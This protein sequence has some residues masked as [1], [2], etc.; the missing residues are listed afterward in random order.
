MG[1]VEGDD[2]AVRW[3]EI[4][5]FFEQFD[6]DRSTE[7]PDGF[8]RFARSGKNREILENLAKRDISSTP[9]QK[10]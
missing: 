3:R 6:F 4:P 9:Q 5:A 7:L 10:N 1:W 8:E 2:P